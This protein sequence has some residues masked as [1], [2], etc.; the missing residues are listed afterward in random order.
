[1]RKS[2]RKK[3]PALSAAD[4]DLLLTQ[5]Q[6]LKEAKNEDVKPETLNILID[7]CK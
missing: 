3:K 7:E 6:K 5:L 4:R 2:G 1:V